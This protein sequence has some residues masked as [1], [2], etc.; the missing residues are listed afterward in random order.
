VDTYLVGGAVRDR[1]L[2]L[3]GSDRDWVVV[4]ATPA[5]MTAQ[6]FRPVGRDFPVFLH[7]E[8]HEEYALARTERKHGT[9]HQGF[10]FHTGPEVT[11]EDD[12]RR[13]DLTVNAIAETPDGRL[14]DPYHG[15]ADLESRL[16][17]HVSPAFVE[18][19][20]RVLRVARFAARLA[21]F[22]FTV[23]DETL[24]LMR[25][26]TASGELATLS[27]ER[28]WQ[29]LQ[30]ALETPAPQR[31]VE[32]LRDCGAL[33]AL[34]PEVDALFGVPQV[35]A[36]HPEIDTGRHLL[37]TLG[38]AAREGCPSR[39]V[40][41]LLLHDLG[42]GVTPADRLPSHPGHEVNGAPLIEAVCDRLKAP[43]AY[44]ELARLTGRWHLHVHRA[45]ELRPATVL[46]LM[47]ACDALRRPERFLEL[48]WACEIDLRGRAGREDEAY[49][50]RAQLAA[51]LAAVQAVD[52]ASVDT[53]GLAGAEI[54]AAIR[55]A[56]LAALARWRS[57]A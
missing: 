39:I 6:G 1:L 10:V 33:A 25:E 50:Q 52:H 19:P 54:G 2:G 42:K 40:F 13:R 11:L 22:G 30:R 51:A 18:D 9:G 14:I 3:P 8:T 17:R 26:I 43:K 15:R 45:A 34:L 4:G 32:V 12:L 28:V 49:P 38:L 56:R 57:A 23:A 24:A 37:L 53:E 5:L 41:A 55:R 7:P 21:P 16:L 47:E 44:R 46:K 35:A 29:E 20:L 36:H 27:P 48:L 31:F